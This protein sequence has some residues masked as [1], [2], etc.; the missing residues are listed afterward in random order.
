MF[1]GAPDGK[2]LLQNA[3]HILGREQ[4]GD[5]NCQTFTLVIIN[6][7]QQTQLPSLFGAVSDEVVQ[8]H[9]I[10]VFGS[11]SVATVPATFRET[12]FRSYFFRLASS[13]APKDSDSRQ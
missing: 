1:R 4:M 6:H 13:L 10:F 12:A 9:M 3:N 11:M 5:F 7:D 8:P 2:Q